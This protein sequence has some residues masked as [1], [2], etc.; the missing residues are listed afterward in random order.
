[1]TH[2]RSGASIALSAFILFVLASP[3]L[4]QA[5]NGPQWTVHRRRCAITALLWGAYPGDEEGADECRHH[6]FPQAPGIFEEG[7][8]VAE[9]GLGFPLAGEK[10]SFE[11]S[12]FGSFEIVW[13]DVTVECGESESSGVLEGGDPGRGAIK[14]TFDFCFVVGEGFPCHMRGGPGGEGWLEFE[15][16]LELVYIGSKAK[17]EKH[18]G[19]FGVLLTPKGANFYSLETAACKP[20]LP[21][22]LMG[23]TGSLIAEI[24]PEGKVEETAALTF[25]NPPVANYWKWEGG[26]VK[27]FNAAL[28]SV[29]QAGEE[30]IEALGSNMTTLVQM[31]ATN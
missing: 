18:E 29:V 30:T 23:V 16:N 28:N 6:D 26:K 10:W 17:A 11:S 20:P 9:E 1:M 7:Y 14:S 12:E 15:A 8:E 2:A 31:G 24:A 25:P 21:N 3:S 27:E 5:V 13:P 22:G 4:A 19:P